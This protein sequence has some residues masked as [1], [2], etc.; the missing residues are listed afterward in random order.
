MKRKQ[1]EGIRLARTYTVLLLRPDYSTDNYGQDTY[2]THIDALNVEAAIRLARVEALQADTP[3]EDRKGLSY[4]NLEDYFV[5]LVAE[6]H[7]I[8]INPGDL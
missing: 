3:P 1:G 2:M 4:N 7:V 6:G 5:L 8:D